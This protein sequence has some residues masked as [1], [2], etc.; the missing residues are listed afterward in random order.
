MGIIDRIR[1]KTAEPQVTAP[2][3]RG[4]SATFGWYTKFTIGVD[5]L[6]L[7]KAGRASRA[8]QEQFY[9]L[10]ML[11]EQG[12]A[13]DIDEGFAV[14]E[15]HL[16]ALEDD[17]SEVLGLPRRFDG[18]LSARVHK[19]TAS[20]DFRVQL[21]VRVGSIAVPPQRTGPVLRVGDELFLLDV[22]TLTA[23]QA[24]ER[25]AALPAHTESANVRLVAELQRAQELSRSATGRTLFSLG[26]LEKFTTVTPAKVG[27]VVEPQEDGS[28]VVE[29][30]LGEG[31][32]RTVVSRRL[33]QL[34]RPSAATDGSSDEVDPPSGV[35][36]VDDTL[37]LLEADQLAGVQEV[38]ERPRI[39]AALV[40]SFL[41]APGSFYDPELV[42]VDTRFS[43][44]VAGLG[45]IAPVSFEL[46]ATSGLD[47]F[48]GL[49][50]VS[51]VQALVE[52]VTTPAQQSTV[53]R[54]VADAWERGE[55]VLT[56]HEEV[57][58]ISNRDHVKE[59]LEASRRRIAALDLPESDAVLQESSETGRTVT[60]GMHIVEA[61]G[62]ADQLRG[63]ALEA[64]PLHPV[65]FRSLCRDPYPHQRD[66]IEWM[67]GLM[68]SALQAQ[69]SDPAR[70][71]GALLADDMGLG[72][73][74][75]ML[76]A[77]AE[78]Q[79]TQRALGGELLS[80]L[81]VLPLALLENWLAEIQSA[82]GT[83]HGPFEDVVVLQGSGLADYRFRGAARETAAR[84]ED[85][86]EHGMVRS[87][88]IHASLRVGPS[89]GEARLDRPGV[90]VLTT[91]E[92]LRRY[93]VSLGLVDWGIVVFDEAQ[94]VKNPEIL[95]TRAAKGLKA[96]FKL[97]ATGTPVENSLR[98]FWSL[99]DTAQ[100]GLLGS[101]GQFQEEWVTPMESATAE[102]H[103]RL[104]RDLRDAVGSFMLRRVKEDHLENL[105]AKHV[106]EYRRAM[107]AAQVAAYDAVLDSHKSRA[108]E[109]GATLKTLQELATVSLHPG[110]LSGSLSGGQELLATSA[111]TLA[112]TQDI[113][114]GVKVKE[115]KAI[116]FA[117]T[118]E[119]Q[120]AL[121][122]WLCDRYGLRID[123]VNGDTA[124]TGRGETR[125]KKIR[126]FEAHE[127]FNV[128]ILSPLA[129]GVG[130]T[131]VGAN[132][133]IHLERH[134]NPAKEA[135]A[136]DRIHRIGQVR[137]VHVHYPVA[138]HPDLDSFDVN[139]D[140][141]LRSK[142]ALKDAVV[143][144]QE[145]TQAQLE[146]SL[147][148]V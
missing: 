99:V 141:L 102:E 59:V 135:Q 118:K 55:D 11:T 119:M 122:L 148:L 111:R 147:G 140:R 94:A 57:V 4:F 108:G 16:A 139:L 36:R 64:R 23:L 9:V 85:L 71:Q 110:L 60:V 88:R 95:A 6:E 47:W 127:G 79:R 116:V 3:D 1:R 145:V 105:P 83:A 10:D 90:L 92:T 112:A 24:V 103:E 134:W 12:H 38:R 67:S 34:D 129:V 106:H 43:V 7:A 143:V 22:P 131:V 107:P 91:Y 29:P 128:I 21:E 66:G 5:E 138:I 30:D 46:A 130:L 48:G 113:L 13:T 93:Q 68:G 17:D 44:R 18:E 74:F 120:R 146:Q 89:W 28:L 19:Y 37:V 115:E 137:D 104:G 26:A 33:H 8:V 52:G 97:L 62:I 109:M 86:D 41:E 63:Q 70:I 136:T 80:V 101:W 75:M 27:L 121:A 82:F 114:D 84:P 133:A 58:D 39:P 40:P 123:I 132:H 144:P 124:A 125:M 51:G 25:H 61:L 15:D 50:S 14:S 56:H 96:R 69:E 49:T 81:A 65:D 78:A 20:Q 87:D 31:L 2:L 42:D 73:T 126:A 54:T 45:V 117:K 98:D 100:P 53:E 72:K 35:L 142:T 32:D 77:L 76:A